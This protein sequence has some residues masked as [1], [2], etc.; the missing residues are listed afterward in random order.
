MADF[1]NDGEN[2]QHNQKLSGDDISTEDV[3]NGLTVQLIDFSS[4]QV[5]V[6]CPTCTMPPEYCEFGA[7][8]DK[9]APWILEN[10]QEAL[11]PDV[12]SELLG[13]ASLDDSEDADVNQLSYFVVMT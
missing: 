2:D 13:K 7:T 12:L 10:C 8:F 9:C 4:P 11:S 5:V 1:V 6:Y 3:N